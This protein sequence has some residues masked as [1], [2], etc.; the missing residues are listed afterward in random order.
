MG[1]EIIQIQ[2]PVVPSS[3][4]CSNRENQCPNRQTTILNQYKQ[5]PPGPQGPQGLTGPQGPPGQPG[6][7]GAEVMKNH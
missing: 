7:P 4:N 6:I 1:E 2:Q 5:G 3:K